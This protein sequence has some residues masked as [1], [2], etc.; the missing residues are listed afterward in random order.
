MANSTGRKYG[1]RKKGT[2][3]KSTALTKEVVNDFIND[4]YL[5]FCTNFEL[6]S[7]KDKVSVYVK[8]LDF[9]LPKMKSVEL[10]DNTKQAERVDEIIAKLREAE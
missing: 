9:V 8:M 2:P 10:N 7:P 3:N 5:K 1:G 4:N 6:L